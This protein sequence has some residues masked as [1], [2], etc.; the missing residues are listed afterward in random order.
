MGLLTSPTAGGSSKKFANILIKWEP[1]VS[2]LLYIAGIIWFLA[3]A[4][5][6]YNAGTYFSEN[7]LL[8][9]L[10]TNEFSDGSELARLLKALEAEAADHPDTVPH[11][12]I[13]AQFRQLGLQVYPHNFTLRYPLG[14]GSVFHGENT[15]AVLRAPRSGSTEALVLSAPY[16]RPGAP[17]PPNHAAVAMLVALAKYFRRQVYWAKDIVFLVTE[18]EQLGVA[19]WLSAYHQQPVGHGLLDAGDLPGRAGSIQAAINLEVESATVSHVDVL[20]EGLNGQLPNLDLV[21]MAHWICHQEHIQHTTQGRADHPRPH[22]EAGYRHSLQTLLHMMASPAAGTPTGNHGHYL[23]YGIQAVTLRALDDRAMPGPRSG[24]SHLARVLEGM[25]RSLNN[26]LER[27]HQS[28]FFYLMPATGRYISIG[29]YMP[30]FALVAIGIVLRALTCWLRLPD[31]DDSERQQEAEGAESVGKKG[32]DACDRPSDPWPLAAVLP[33][34]LA[35]HALGAVTLAG[36]VPLTQLLAAAGW[37][38]ER[39]V[40]AGLLAVSVGSLLLPAITSRR[41]PLSESGRLLL[42]CVTLIELGLL[43]FT[44]A[45]FNISLAL[46]VTTLYTPVA[47]SARYYSSAPARLLASLCLLLV[48]PFIL[49]LAAVALGAPAL[50]WRAVL[51]ADQRALAVALVDSLVYGARLLDVACTVLLPLWLQMWTL[52]HCG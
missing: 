25:F 30:P 23:R 48:H 28:F 43:V 12:W 29:L 45:L 52:V 40:F 22:S 16:R 44:A 26:L 34:V 17:H 33:C 37:P 24:L 20:V 41:S 14:N 47:L 11:P 39:A 49:Q 32:G 7:A 2:P 8:P 19:A 38:T 46:I 27:F 10:V 4:Y 36:L 18:H 15:Y 1:A 51:A 42:R 9:G 21:K 35:P 50:A 3:L 6:P 5:H 13:R 31:T